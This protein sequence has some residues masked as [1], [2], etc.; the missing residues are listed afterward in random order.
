MNGGATVAIGGSLVT[1]L[2]AVVSPG[3]PLEEIIGTTWQTAAFRV[4]VLGG[5]VTLAMAIRTLIK[6]VREAGVSTGAERER[7][8]AHLEEADALIPEFRGLLTRHAEAMEQG[9]AVAEKL[10][11][12]IDT[13]T[14]A[15]AE[16][17]QDI[18]WLMQNPAGASRV[19]P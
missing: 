8:R 17:R 16:F 12:F 9:K 19:T 10:N 5:L 1:L 6:S 14:D 4:A 18:R 3:T 15:N 11:G 2:G 7:I 13:Q